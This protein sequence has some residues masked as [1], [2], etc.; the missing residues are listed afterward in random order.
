ML[1]RAI[2]SRM[3]DA[4]VARALTHHEATVD[5]DGLACDVACE[6]TAEEEHGVG[7]FFGAALALLGDKGFAHLPE[8]LSLTFCVDFIALKAS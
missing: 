6:R 3:R 2:R 7:N 8:C 1:P 4:R 5:R